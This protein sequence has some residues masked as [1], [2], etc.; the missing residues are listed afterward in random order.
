MLL[1]ICVLLVIV[2]YVIVR[3]YMR[4][5]MRFWSLQPVF[6]VYNMRYWLSP[7]GII[8]TDTPVQLNKFVNMINIQVCKIQDVLEVNQSRA[9]QLL[10]D[11]YIGSSDPRVKYFPTSSTILPYLCHNN[12]DAFIGIYYT[13]QVL[14]ERTTG[15]RAEGAQ[16]AAQGAPAPAAAQGAPAPAT[17]QGAP[18]PAAAQGAA[19]GAAP[20]AETVITYNNVLGVI[21]ARPLDV[22]RYKNKLMQETFRVYYVDHLCVH[23]NH[24]RKDIAPQLIQT[25]PYQISRLH[26]SSHK[27]PVTYLFKREGDLNAIVPLVAYTTYCIDIEGVKSLR[28]PAEYTCCAMSADHMAALVAFIKVQRARFEWSILADLSALLAL[29]KTNN[30]FLYALVWR[31]TII[32][33]YAFRN[34]PIYYGTDNKRAIECFCVLSSV[35]NSTST[36]LTGFTMALLD[37]T[38]QHQM[39]VHYVLLEDLADAGVLLQT[40]KKTQPVLFALPTAF[41]FYNYACYSAKNSHVMLL[42]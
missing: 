19:Q 37:I 30:I 5:K 24:R 13:P 14:L 38:K 23:T 8:C 4:I 18:A 42:Y 3:G 34:T 39:S 6:H 16:G 28:L 29:I 27:A 11:H 1:F 7:P 20:A 33:M 35:N 9:C 36:L 12:G 32:A 10:H 22:Q 41:F 25:L 40:L 21:T 31:G 26:Q 17:V 15:A 2:S